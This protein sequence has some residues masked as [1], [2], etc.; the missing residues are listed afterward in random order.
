[1]LVEESKLQLE[2]A[3]VA[4]IELTALKTLNWKIP[5]FSIRH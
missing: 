1:M 5:N 3:A 4:E 2:R